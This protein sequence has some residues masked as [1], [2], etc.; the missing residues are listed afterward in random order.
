[1]I[2]LD[3]NILVRLIVNDDPVQ[4]KK[5]AKLIDSTDAFFVPLTVTLELEWVLRGH[6]QQPPAAVALALRAVLEISNLHFE[7]EPEVLRAL[8]HYENGLDF[9]DALHHAK[10]EGCK[11]MQTFDKNF[12]HKAQTG[13]L[14]PPVKLLK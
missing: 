4:G 1:M 8:R 12:S 14:Y 6:Y 2:A 5:A 10:S 11:M 13:K 3:T 9:A 7:C